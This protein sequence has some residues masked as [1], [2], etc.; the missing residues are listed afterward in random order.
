MSCRYLGNTHRPRQTDTAQK[1]GKGQSGS[2]Q[3]LQ[4]VPE[5]HRHIMQVAVRSTSA[6][7]A[8]DLD[9]HYPSS[10]SRRI[11]HCAGRYMQ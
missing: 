9:V 10:R 3:G 1:G 2:H 6:S 5:Q 4:C 8:A 11:G 7:T